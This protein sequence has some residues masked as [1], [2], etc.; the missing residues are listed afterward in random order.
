MPDIFPDYS[1]PI[2][3]RGGGR[4]LTMVRRCMPTSSRCSPSRSKKR[5]SKLKAKVKDRRV[6]I[7][8]LLRMESDSRTTSFRDTDSNHRSSGWA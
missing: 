6:D 5:A 7:K 3:Q 8:N 2:V 1:A 4:E